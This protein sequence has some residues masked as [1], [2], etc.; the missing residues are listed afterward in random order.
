MTDYKQKYLK[1]K[2]KYLALRGGEFSK[3]DPSYYTLDDSDKT[4]WY[5]VC[6]N[7]TDFT[8]CD[9]NKSE[10]CCSICKQSI[11]YHRVDNELNNNPL[12]H[13]YV[14][15]T[16]NLC[17]ICHMPEKKHEYQLSYYTL[18]ENK[19]WYPICKNVTTFV[20]RDETSKQLYCTY[21]DNDIEYH[22]I[23]NMLNN[24]PIKHPYFMENN[25][26]KICHMPQ[27]GHIEK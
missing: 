16:D 20:K 21:C 19:I 26:C 12:K 6:K 15:N 9:G 27:K 10:K 2:R 14:I 3:D 11:N 17:K 25:L 13:K 8:N 22:Q 7:T 4:T 5:P 23:N 18:A 1:Y 24:N